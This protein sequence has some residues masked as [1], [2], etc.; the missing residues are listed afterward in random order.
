MVLDQSDCIQSMNMLRR[1]A[2]LLF[3]PRAAWL[4]IDRE[5]GPVWKLYVGWLLPLTLLMLGAV[6]ASQFLYKGESSWQQPASLVQ[7]LVSVLWGALA[8]AVQLTAAAIITCVGARLFG[9]RCDLGRAFS[10]IFH[11]VAGVLI[12]ALLQVLLMPVF[13]L[14]LILGAGWSVYL[15]LEGMPVLMDIDARRSRVFSA[16]ILVVFLLVNILLSPLIERWRR[17]IDPLTAPVVTEMVSGQAAGP[18]AEALSPA[19]RIEQ[20][21]RDLDRAAREA[22][23]ANEHNDSLAAAQAARD[24]VSAIAATVAGGEER[25]P[26]SITQL[27]EWFPESLLGMELMSLQVEPWGG[28]SSQAILARGIYMKEGGQG[29]DLELRVFD[30]ASAGALLAESAASN[31]Q[32]RQE[33]ETEATLERVYREGARSV[34]ELRWKDSGRVEITYVLANGVRVQ[35]Q[36]RG[37]DLHALHQSLQALP[38]E[39]LE[40]D[41]MVPVGKRVQPDGAPQGG[42]G[43]EA[44]GPGSAAVRKLASPGGGR[45]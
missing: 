45:S 42:R 20:A 11:A 28:M 40:K 8:L 10:L 2:R 6:L 27:T 25:V 24:A 17:V 33:G 39:L 13:P 1:L 5:N 38:F 23:T 21:G 30:P 19:Q 34:S 3:S 44:S 36:G 35:A 16:V 18:L 9:G 31:E 7:P 15:L 41:R 4:A 37:I 14:L 26:L 32:G 29:R 43:H 22:G 12:G